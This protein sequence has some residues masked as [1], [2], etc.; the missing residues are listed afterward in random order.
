LGDLSP[1]VNPPDVKLTTH[2]HIMPTLRI[3]GAIPPPPTRL[4]VVVLSYGQR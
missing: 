1:G 3:C 4:H 2:L